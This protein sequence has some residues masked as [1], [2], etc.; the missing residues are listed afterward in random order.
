MVITIRDRFRLAAMALMG[1]S[2]SV[3]AVSARVV[4]PGQNLANFMP[5]NFR[6]VA[7]HGYA[8]NETA[9]SGIRTLVDSFSEAPMIVQDAAGAEIKNHWLTQVMRRPNR[10]RSQ[11]QLWEATV[12]PWFLCGNAFWEVVRNKYTGKPV[13]F[14]PMRPDRVKIIPDA[15]RFIGGYMYNILG[16]DYPLAVEDVIHFKFE[17]P[18]DDYWGMSPLLPAFSR[19]DGDNEQAKIV[20]TVLENGA[21]PGLAVLMERTFN[22]QAEKDRWYQKWEQRF[23]GSGRG[24]VA[25]LDYVKEIKTIGMDFDKMAVKDLSQMTEAKILSCIGTPPIMTGASVG[26]EN[27]TYA[28]AEGF[29]LIFWENTISTLHNAAAD[30]IQARLYDDLGAGETPHFDASKIPAL[31]SIRNAEQAAYLNEVQQGVRTVNEY[32][33]T[34]GLE[35][36]PE[37]DVLYKP[38]SQQVMDALGKLTAEPVPVT[39][40]ASAKP[41]D[42]TPAATGAKSCGD[43][44]FTDD[45]T[46]DIPTAK[47]ACGCGD[48]THTHAP[49]PGPRQLKTLE[50]DG[51]KVRVVLSSRK[52]AGNH[53]GLANA[54]QHLG[55]ISIAKGFSDR[56]KKWARAEFAHQ[57]ATIKACLAEPKKS[58]KADGYTLTPAQ[59]DQAAIEMAGWTDHALGTVEDLMI[60]LQTA[61]RLATVKELGID[62]AIEN[63]GIAQ[64]KT[65][66]YKFAQA[67]SKT[68]ADDVRAI[69]VQAR[70]QE[71]TTEG[72]RVLLMDKF[73]EWDSVRADTVARTETIR[74]TN[75]AT[76]DAYRDAGIEEMVWTTTGSA[77]PY[78]EELDGVIVSI[79]EPFFRQGD[80]FAPTVITTDED[81]N[82]VEETMPTMK[83]DYE[84]VETPPLHPCCE[85]TIT[86]QLAEE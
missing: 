33:A 51:R 48:A 8:G 50:R 45:K 2:K 86:A 7:K 72:I 49:A 31:R 82:E 54:A 73:E 76:V 74:S 75:A 55:R 46:A 71:L 26:L 18:M 47:C 27:A 84:T 5:F 1:G 35:P 78:C 65:H 79:G 22:D 13:E 59:A 38:V 20:K 43:K 14:W 44:A 32:R 34:R 19:I 37:G 64:A 4:G 41:A 40:A 21:V 52:A 9:Y 10:F 24:K 53:E 30:T 17:N 12:I 67:I 25:A 69:F 6:N 36:L 56:F 68:S 15:E 66:A 80:R 77:C 60:E 81:G 42:T 29:R 83:L 3:T 39:P 58:V 61:A 63:T 85:C 23:G 28:N 62:Y 11:A 57:A 70:E 16:H